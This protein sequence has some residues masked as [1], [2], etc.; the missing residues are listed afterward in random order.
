VLRDLIVQGP[1][2]PQRVVLGLDT[3]DDY[4]QHSPYFGAIVGR[5]ANRIGN[6]RFRLGEREIALVPNENGNVLHGGP[7]SFGRQPWSLL[8]HD[9][10]RVHLGLVSEDGEGGFPGR[11][12]ALATYEFVAAATLRFTLQPCPTR[13]RP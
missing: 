2:G 13:R 8:G 1:A 3:L 7:A 4:V 9:S 10:R 11:L 6:A 12:F 5:Y